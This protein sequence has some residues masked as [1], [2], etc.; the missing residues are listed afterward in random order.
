MLTEHQWAPNH[1][2]LSLDVAHHQESIRL[3]QFLKNYYRKR[4]REKIKSAIADG[5][6]TVERNQSPHLHL[7]KLKPSSPLFPGDKVLIL[8]EKKPEPPVDFNYRVLYED[9]VIFVIEKPANLPVHPSGRYFFNTLLVHLR[10][11]GHKNPL[12][13]GREYYLVHRIDK[14]T[15]GILVLAKERETAAHLVNQFAKRL[16]KKR[17]FAIARGITPDEFEVAASIG[18][19]TKSSVALRMA[20]LAPEE[21][22]LEAYTRYKKISTHGDY[23]LL[24]CFPRTGRQ[25][26]IRVHLEIAGHPLVGDK[27]YGLTDSEALQFFERHRLSAE[28][29]ARLLL[30]RHA[31]HA[32]GI[33]F[34]H[35]KTEKTMT[36]ESA[37]PPDM[38]EFLQKAE[39]G[40]I[41]TV[42]VNR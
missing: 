26:Q 31:L 30:S 27:L 18:R 15:S 24:E 42:K 36:F 41:F 11:E 37:L 34:V 28:L 4:S 21:G 25:H 23:T 29:E 40:Q 12:D 19:D 2:L 38:A 13:L 39:R 7:G 33:E 16:T 1:Y 17:Y 22:G 8:T 20:E 10:T 9:E 3:D 6:V 5:K 32:G 14:E 35:P